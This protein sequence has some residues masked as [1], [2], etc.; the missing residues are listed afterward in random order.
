M[1]GFHKSGHILQLSYITY[2][3]VEHFATTRIAPETKFRACT[4][5]TVIV[6]SR[7]FTAELLLFIIS[8]TVAARSD[9]CQ[10]LIVN[11]H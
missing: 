4:Y 5:N 6:I 9:T 7:I 10:Q 3:E 8:I 2:S 1:S 11:I